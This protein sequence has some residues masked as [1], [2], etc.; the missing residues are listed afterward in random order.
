M[1]RLLNPIYCRRSDC[2]IRRCILL[3]VVSI[4]SVPAYEGPSDLANSRITAIF[5]LHHSQTL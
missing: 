4:L 5:S 1:R 2:R 3:G